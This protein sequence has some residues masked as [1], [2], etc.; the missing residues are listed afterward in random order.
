MKTIVIKVGS[1]VL[2]NDTELS[3]QRMLNLVEFI[4]LL[5]KKY[6]IILVS[7]GAVAAGYTALNIN[8]SV[9]QNRQALASIGQ[10]ML[11][12]SYT[13]KFK[14]YDINIAQLLLTQYD[15]KSKNGALNTQNVLETL[16][17]YNILPIINENDVV[18]TEELVLGDNDQL[19]A[20]VCCKF[21]CDMLV[22]LTDI[23]GFYDK[24][25]KEHKGAIKY[26]EINEIEE[27]WLQLKPNPTNKF[28]TGGIKTKI[29]AADFVLKHNKIMFLSSGFD[30]HDAKQFLLNNNKTGGTIFKNII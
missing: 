25:P 4:Y 7:S 26:E 11:M 21:N 9:I 27:K 23:D 22:I 18:A 3:E 5:K 20:H 10:P 2:N 29:L 14:K 1:A 6:Q 30:L 16:F 15:L 12:K 8:K 24:N 19:S 28:A 13:K 17:K